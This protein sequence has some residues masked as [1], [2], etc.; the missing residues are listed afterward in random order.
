MKIQVVKKFQYALKGIGIAIREEAHM[1]FHLMASIT[2]ICLSFYLG[3]SG[4]DW[5]MVLLAIGLVIGAELIN[6]AIE[7]MVD[8]MQPEYHPIA[9][10]IKDIAAGGVLI[11]SLIASIVGVIIFSPYLL[12]LFRQLI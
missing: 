12:E 8:L 2:V 1:K 11:C 4:S 10:K 3:L 5:S 6:S 9:G 7:N